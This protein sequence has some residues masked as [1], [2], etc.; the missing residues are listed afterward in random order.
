M[1]TGDPIPGATIEIVSTGQTVSTDTDGNFVMTGS[2]RLI[3]IQASAEGATFSRAELE[4][5]MALAEGGIAELVA[6]QAAAVGA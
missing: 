3:E 2:G 6:A 5:L 1:T 4:K